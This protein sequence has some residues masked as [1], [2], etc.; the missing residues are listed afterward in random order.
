MITYVADMD[1]L[2][3]NV[4]S[5][6]HILEDVKER[7]PAFKVTLFTI[8]NR[9]SDETIKWYKQH[10][11]IALAPHGYH[12]TRGECLAW[13]KHEARAKIQAAMDRGIDAPIF[14]APAWLIN[15][16][17]YEACRDLGIA[18]A[19][20][21]D[22]YLHVPNVSVYRYNDPVHRAPKIRTIHG[23]MTNCDVDNF[24]EHMAGDG[25]LSFARK[26]EFIWP[27]EATVTLAE[28]PRETSV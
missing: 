7:H 4:A 28:E 5:R 15:R 19:D 11:W 22:F 2:C 9:T 27:W 1:D 26:A 23:H 18:V 6:L 17:T 16:S 20:H 3:E 10:D 21:K 14:R 24:I 13:T 12:H 8:P 25:R